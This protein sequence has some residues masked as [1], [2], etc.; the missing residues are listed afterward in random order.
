MKEV[1]IYLKNMEKTDSVLNL[2]KA[3]FDIPGVYKIHINILSREIIVMSVQDIDEK[4]LK[5]IIKNNSFE[6]VFLEL[7]F[8]EIRD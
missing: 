4:E 2:N 6:F 1:K 7:N 5:K 3:L 8:E